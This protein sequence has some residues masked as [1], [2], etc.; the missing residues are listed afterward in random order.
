VLHRVTV[1][2]GPNL[3]ARARLARRRA[4][5]PA[6]MTGHT[7]DDQAETILIR[8]LRGSGTT[9]LGAMQP[10]DR[11]P[12]LALRRAETEQLCAELGLEPVRDETNDERILWRSR[13][14]HELLPLA[15]DIAGRDVVPILA[16]TAELLRDDAEV[17]DRL[18]STIDPTD[19]RALA[20]A[21]PAVARHAVRRWLTEDGYPPDAAAVERVLAVARGDAVAC[22]LPGGRRLERSRQAFRI[23]DRPR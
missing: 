17:L 23:V 21:D 9:G 16:R 10:G 2:P 20:A 14:R 4:L 6:A 13:I 1:E 7:L 15:A 12:L 8:L 5:P 11:H 19:A 22:E 3:E 18:A